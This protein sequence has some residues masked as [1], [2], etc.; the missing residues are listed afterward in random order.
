MIVG[1]TLSGRREQIVPAAKVHFQMGNGVNDSGLSRY[2]IFYSVKDS[3]KRMQTDVIDL[4]HMHCWGPLTQI[5][6]L[7]RTF[8]DLVLACKICYIGVLNI[9]DKAIILTTVPVFTTFFIS[10]VPTC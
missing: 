5:E 6:E 2:H 1:A 4:L 7:L 10:S 9:I 8:D 3:L